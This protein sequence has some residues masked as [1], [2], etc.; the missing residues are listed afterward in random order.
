MTL[1]V[2]CREIRQQGIEPCNKRNMPFLIE[3]VET[4]VCRTICPTSFDTTNIQPFA[5]AMCPLIGR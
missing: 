1:R 4:E 2:A 3:F 5:V